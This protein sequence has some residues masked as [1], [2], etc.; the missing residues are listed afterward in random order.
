MLEEHAGPPSEVLRVS[1]R[2]HAAEITPRPDAR[3]CDAED[4]S[5]R[6][7][8]AEVDPEGPAEART[9]CP[10]HRVEFLREVTET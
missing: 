10:T 1:R 4:C 9:L 8:L 7:L 6:D 2:D 5:T 3:R